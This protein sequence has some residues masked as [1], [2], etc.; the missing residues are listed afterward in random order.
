MTRRRREEAP[1]EVDWSSEGNP[2]FTNG[3]RVAL[4]TDGVALVFTEYQPF[5]GRSAAPGSFEPRDRVVASLRTNPEK[6]FELVA[7]FA[8]AWN[9]FALEQGKADT[10]PRFRLFGRTQLQL[11]GV[12]DPDDD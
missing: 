5:P 6:Y 1:A 11:E 4:S 2:V 7:S 8:S 12:Q 10:L 3:V 9:R